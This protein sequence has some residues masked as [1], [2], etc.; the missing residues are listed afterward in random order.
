MVN[1]LSRQKIRQKIILL[2]IGAVLSSATFGIFL[3][4][5]DAES[6]SPSLF[7]QVAAL[8]AELSRLERQLQIA[9]SGTLAGDSPSVPELQSII[10]RGIK[11]LVNTQE[12]SGHFKYEHVPYEDRYIDDDNIVR[13]AGALY[14]LGE[15]ARKDIDKVFDLKETLQRAIGYFE[16]LSKEGEFNEEK[17]RC[18]ANSELSTQCKLG[19]TSL[20]LVGVLSFVEVYPELE[21]QHEALITDYVQY[22]VTMKKDVAGFRNYYYISRSEQREVESSFSNGEALLALVRYYQ[23]NQTDEVK[24]IIDEIFDY[25]QS[26]DS[27]FDVPLY[28]W[29]M[30]ALKDMNILWPNDKYVTYAKEYTDWRINGAAVHKGTKNNWCAYLEGVVS[31]YS[32]LE[33]EYSLIELQKH[34]DDMDFWLRKNTYFQISENDVVRL[35][36]DEDGLRFMRIDNMEQAVGGFLTAEDTLTQRIDY[37]QHCLNSYLQKLVDIDNAPLTAK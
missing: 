22:I 6:D 2:T 3:P 33:P 28:L 29:A 31:A 17:F 5:A 25:F 10:K 14:Q 11:W 35:V 7:E 30:S 16:S 24:E 19:A 18:I 8:T 36:R 23:Y 34:R 32:I 12:E 4:S 21:E 20:A 37:T 1:L 27:P 26:E 13:Q 9:T 15:I